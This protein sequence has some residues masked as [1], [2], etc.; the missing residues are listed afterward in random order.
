MTSQ[1]PKNAIDPSKLVAPK[2]TTAN[3]Q[4]TPKKNFAFEQYGN[5]SLNL[6]TSCT[7]EEAVA[8]MLGWLRGPFRLDPNEVNTQNI[9][10]E[11]MPHLPK[12]YYSLEDHLLMLREDAIDWVNIILTRTN[13]TEEVKA[14]AFDAVFYCEDLIF[15]ASTYSYDIEEE[16]AKTELCALR[17]DRAKTESKGETYITLR[18]LDTWAKS[19][20]QISIIEDNPSNLWDK[21]ALATHATSQAQETSPKD[22]LTKTKKEHLYTTFALLVEAYSD[23]PNS[24]F[25]SAGKP[26]VDAI[27]RQLNTLAAKQSPNEAPSGQ[28]VEAIKDRIE[29]ALKVKAKTLRNK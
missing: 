24:G 2:T 21:N 25:K 6:S 4:T 18:S 9:S 5:I 27:A 20:Y 12:L 16:L 1:N 13:S 8:K 10:I 11:H 29:E 14:K 22:G 17:I 7:K 15:K 28:S 26:I 19:N 23:M 3:S